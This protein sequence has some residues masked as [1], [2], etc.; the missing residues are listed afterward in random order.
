M[1]PDQDYLNVLCRNDKVL[2]PVGWNK[3]PLPDH[4]FDY[5]T[6]KLLHYNSFEKPW[7]HDHVLYSKEFWDAARTSPFYEDLL[8]IKASV[9]KA[10]LEK[11][12]KGVKGLFAKAIHITKKE[13]VTFKKILDL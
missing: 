2:L 11:E 6:L 10:H 3:M 7:H 5:S 12:E 1:C 4:S 13:E 9:D 8:R